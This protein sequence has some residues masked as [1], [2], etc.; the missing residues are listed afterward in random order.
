MSLP[1]N[2]RRNRDNLFSQ[3]RKP[4]ST[5]SESQSILRSMLRTQN[6]LKNELDRMSHLQSTID[7][8]GVVLQQTMEHHKSLNTKNAQKALTS[9]QKAQQHEQRVLRLSI[10]FFFFVTFYVM[11]SRVLIKFDFITYLWN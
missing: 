7:Q 2:E 6:L 10:A 8:D 9:L 3:R 1:G 5:A 4:S 11:W